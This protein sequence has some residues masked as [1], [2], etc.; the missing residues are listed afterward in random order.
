MRHAERMAERLDRPQDALAARPLVDRGDEGAVDLDL[1][2]GDVG[3]RATAT[4]S[5]CRNRRSRRARRARASSA[6][7][8]IWKW[9]LPTK[10]SSVSSSMMRARVAARLRIVGSS[11]RMKSR[12][13]ACLAATLTLIV[14][15]AP[16]ASSS[17]SIERTASPSTKWVIGSI[18]PSSIASPMNAL[19]GWI[20]PSS[21]RQ[22]TSVSNPTTSWLCDVD[23]GLERAA[24]LAVADRE[25]QP[26]LELHAGGDRLAHVEVEIDR[27]ALGAAA[28]PG[29]WRCRRCG[30]A[31]RSSGRAPDRC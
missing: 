4:N 20:S 18:R 19:G 16:N 31:P 6:A 7:P 1:V 26:L 13:P 2:G 9:L 30:A 14:V 15:P 27:A 10:A 12:S 24:E 8:A 21:S 3:E 29:T 23:L 22:R 25:A 5:R 28:W 11:E 17:C